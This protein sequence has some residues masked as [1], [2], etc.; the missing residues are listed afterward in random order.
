MVKPKLH[1][2]KE[3]TKRGV[4]KTARNVKKAKVVPIPEA[5]A[6]RPV[7]VS[8]P[9]SKANSKQATAVPVAKKSRERLFGKPRE[10]M[11]PRL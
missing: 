8:L 1:H 9:R 3:K 2:M 11:A 4:T 10:T 5:K 7:K 6:S